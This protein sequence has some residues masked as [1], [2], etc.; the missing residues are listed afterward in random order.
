MKSLKS[1]VSKVVSSVG[2]KVSEKNKA[3]GQTLQNRSK[4]YFSSLY[5]RNFRLFFFGQA[6][7][8][9]GTWMQ[10]IALGWLVLNVTNSPFL[11]GFMNAVQFLPMLVLSLYAGVIVDRFSK[12]KILIFTQSS[13]T[14]LAFILGILTHTGTA[15]Y[16]HVLLISFLIGT[17]NSIDMPA[18]Q[19]FY[20]DLVDKKDLMN[21]ISLNSSIFNLARII[22]PAIAGILVGKIGYAPAFYINAIS[23]LP[24][25]YGIYLIKVKD[26]GK[27]G[28]FKGKV[29]SDISDGLKFIRHTPI[30]LVLM[31]LLAIINI[32]MYNFNIYVPTFVKDVLNMGATHYG[33]VMSFMGGGALLGSFF[34]AL[35][36]HKGVRVSYVFVSSVV[37]GIFGIIIGMQKSYNLT[38]AFILIEG[39]AMIVQ[40]NSTNTLIQVNSEDSI[41]GRVMSVYTFIFG[42]LTLFGSLYAGTVSQVLGARWAFSISGIITVV[43]AI[44]IYLKWYRKI[45]VKKP[46]ELMPETIIESPPINKLR[47]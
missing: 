14:I 31:V 40:L 28:S 19:A 38:N 7:S 46:I 33:L 47:K 9:I 32:F 45:S 8:V 16:W 24:V 15:K 20:I 37:L 39:F 2:K 29:F 36:S 26:Q 34:L 3:L 5:Y 41:R 10:N 18:R 27:K 11:L 17:V 21:A 13:L 12:R 1:R 23:F 35:I 30:I 4:L 43:S 42:G 22:G 6:V 44:F 25:I